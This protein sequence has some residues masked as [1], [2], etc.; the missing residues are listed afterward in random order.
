MSIKEL[1]LQPSFVIAPEAPAM[2]A[3]Q[4]MI[5]HK[6]NHVAVGE[7]HRVVGLVS[8]TD[9]LKQLIPASVR[10]P[11][12]MMDLKFAGDSSRMLAANLKKLESIK[13]SEVLQY[14]PP[15]EENC[16]LLEAALLLFQNAGPLAVADAEG[17]FKGM[18]SRRVFVEYLTQQAEA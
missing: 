14:V 18:L 12:G 5:K 16:P 1:P 9:I 13:V 3:L 15:V 4:S 8:I 6:I 2:Q 17:N 7:G 11:D 10:Q